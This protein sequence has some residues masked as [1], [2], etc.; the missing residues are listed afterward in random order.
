M[1]LTDYIIDIALI[2]LVFLQV[3]GRKLTVRALLLPIVLI[4]VAVSNYLHT[5]P[6]AGNDLVLI[7]ALTAAG[8]ALGA[9]SGACTRVSRN[10]AGALVAKAGPLAAVAWVVG[11]GFRFSFAVYASNGGAETIGRFSAA[12]GISAGSAWTAALI[13]MAL[14]EVLV[15]TGWMAWR[16]RELFLPGQGPALAS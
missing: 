10:R 7:G 3:R 4:A 8:A 2:A 9:L 13:L 16:G 11:M 5:V 6:T 12:H 15:R 1:S 14:A